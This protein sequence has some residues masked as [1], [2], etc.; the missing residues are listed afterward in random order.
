[1]NYPQLINNLQQQIN[2]TQTEI[3]S[4]NQQIID[5]ENTLEN[6][7]FFGDNP[8]NEEMEDLIAN[9]IESQ[10]QHLE[11]KHNKLEIINNAQVALLQAYNLLKQYNH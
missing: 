5:N 9:Q 3:L 1:M 2:Q 7:G 6:M 8:E 11:R 4:V 10:Q